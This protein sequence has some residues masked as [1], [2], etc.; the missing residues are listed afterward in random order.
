MPSAQNLPSPRDQELTIWVIY[1]DLPNYPGKWVLVPAPCT[2]QPQ[3]MV[4]RFWLADSLDAIRT[5][6]PV[7]LHQMP[8]FPDDDPTIVECWL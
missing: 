6:L 3:V 4:K 2:D 7:G 5:A 8:R 1:F